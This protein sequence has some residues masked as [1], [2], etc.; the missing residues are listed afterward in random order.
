LPK[1]YFWQEDFMLERLK[2]YLRAQLFRRPAWMDVRTPKV[3]LLVP[4]NGTWVRADSTTPSRLLDHY[5]DAGTSQEE[6]LAAAIWI[7]A[8]DKP[9]NRPEASEAFF[10]IEFWLS[11][12]SSL[13]EGAC[14]KDIWAWE[15]SSMQAVRKRRSDYS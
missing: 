3:Q 10:H 11:A 14:S 12:V 4:I 8:D 7:H 1:T 9:W 15:E 5:L 6:V 2:S 13:L